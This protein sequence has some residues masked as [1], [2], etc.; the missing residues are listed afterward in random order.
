MTLG[1]AGF[2]GKRAP[3]VSVVVNCCHGGPGE[4][5]GGLMQAFSAILLAPPGVESLRVDETRTT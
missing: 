2:E 1:T 4:D 5:V 3:A